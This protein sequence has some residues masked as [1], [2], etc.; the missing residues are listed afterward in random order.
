MH[1]QP[2]P[3]AI[4]GSTGS[5]GKQA[6]QIVDTHPGLFVIEILTA[7]SNYELLISQAI[8]FKPNVVVIGD[9]SRYTF[10]SNALRNEPI[11]VYT[12]DEALSQV[13]EMDS[14]QLVIMAI[15]GFAALKPI[16]AAIRNKKTIALANKECLVVAGESL[17]KLA[18]ENRTPIIPID[19][20]HSAIFQC[21]AG[22][23]NNLITNVSLTA[24]GGPFIDLNHEDLAAVTP[25]M[26]LQHPHWK[27]GDKITIDSATLMNKGLEAIE[28][29][30]L[31]NL[32]PDQIEILIH[33]QSLVHSLVTFADGSTKA[34]MSRPD[35]RLPIQYAMTYPER[36]QSLVKPLSLT[37]AGPLTFE[38]PDVK[39]FRNLALA[40]QALETGGSLPCVLNAANEIAVN[41]F[42]HGEIGFLSIPKIVEE[43][44]LRHQLITRPTINDFDEIDRIARELAKQI[45]KR[46]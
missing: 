45:V 41:A 35:M 24:S 12:G 42:L 21:L 8:K 16:V 36:M 5:I 33:R 30:W 1:N 39:K 44:M 25:I 29:R 15:M 37:E 31:F 18:L 11:K 2:K 23:G 38:R 34:Q 43:S 40:L 32:K 7:H 4:F 26:A 13:M 27:M 46:T 3:V 17:T 19:S 9:K 22:E 20:E 14:F 10:V 28:A 6:L